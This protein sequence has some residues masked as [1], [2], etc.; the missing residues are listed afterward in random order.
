MSHQ[1]SS[2][3]TFIASSGKQPLGLTFTLDVI[4][5]IYYP[6]T[7]AHI[8]CLD[9]TNSQSEA[10]QLPP[11]E[12]ASDKI[13]CL[14]IVWCMWYISLSDG[15]R[16]YSLLTIPT[17]ILHS[18]IQDPSYYFN[19]LGELSAPS[20]DDHPLPLPPGSGF[21]V[22]KVL[23]MLSGSCFRTIQAFS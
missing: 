18:G 14:R 3:I 20:V 8:L 4:L 2:S 19:T 16:S 17:A 11:T 7:K 1:G 21:Q 23:I 5:A 15:Q 13:T 12:F 10:L 9:L 6:Y 22:I